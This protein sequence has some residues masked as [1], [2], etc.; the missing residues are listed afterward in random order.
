MNK[1]ILKA[2]LYRQRTFW[3][4]FLSR[5]EY[6]K[7]WL[8]E[9]GMRL[10]LRKLRRMW[11]RTVWKRYCGNRRFANVYEIS[12]KL[13]SIILE[14][15]KEAKN[16]FDIVKYNASV[17]IEQ[18][19]ELFNIKWRNNLVLSN[20]KWGYKYTFNAKY[21]IITR[22]DKWGGWGN[23]WMNYFNGLKELFGLNAGELMRELSLLW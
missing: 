16:S 15:L 5:Y 23:K 7:F 14:T 10:E 6:E 2:L 4:I 13:M 3:E 20:E 18:V 8:T 1:K 22:W 17:K 21:N 11:L 12:D 9:W 19:K